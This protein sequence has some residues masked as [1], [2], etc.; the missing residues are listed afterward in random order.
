MRRKIPTNGGTTSWFRTVN[1]FAY[2]WPL[3]L[4]ACFVALFLFDWLSQLLSLN[5]VSGALLLYIK[6]VYWSFYESLL[7]S[8]WFYVGVPA[9]FVLQLALPVQRNAPAFGAS[10][11]L[12]LFYTLSFI[13]FLALVAPA[14]WDFLRATYEQF[15]PYLRFELVHD[16][17]A[18]TQLLLGYLMIDFLGWFHHLVRHKVPVFWELHMVHHSQQ[19]LN[20]FSN[21]R[22]HFI[23]SFVSKLIKFVPAFMFAEAFDVVLSYIVLHKVLDHLNHANVRTN[24]GWLRYILVTPQSHRVHHSVQQ[25]HF[26]RNFGVSLSLWDHLFDTQHR[27]YDV[28]PTT[29]VPDAVFPVE[30][31]KDLGPLAILRCF[32][33]QNIYPL[34]KAWRRT[35]T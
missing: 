8:P 14:F 30:Q 17:P 21:H 26:D 5:D 12:D 18:A 35:F 4:V 2:A 9:I 6:R 3:L 31:Q 19:Q 25:E 16:L 7:F 32:V 15:F 11:R 20:P 1:G 34:K 28:Y 24:L 22:F 27:D 10:T 23:E 33:K 29:G 13:P